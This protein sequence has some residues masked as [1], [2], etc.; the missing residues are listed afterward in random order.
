MEAAIESLD[1]SFLTDLHDFLSF[2][3]IHVAT[4]GPVVPGPL[5]WQTNR[6]AC[7]CWDSFRC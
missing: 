7:S 4:F 3:R 5:G 1:Q 2:V 6:A